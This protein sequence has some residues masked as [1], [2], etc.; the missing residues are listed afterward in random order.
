MSLREGG[1]GE[2]HHGAVFEDK[3]EILITMH[4]HCDRGER[5]RD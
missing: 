2:S 5:N 3:K 1:S 4:K